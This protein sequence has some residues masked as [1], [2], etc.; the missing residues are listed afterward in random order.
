MSN[1]YYKALSLSSIDEEKF[2]ALSFL[3]GIKDFKKEEFETHGSQFE[4]PRDFISKQ[5]LIKEGDALFE[6]YM[7][8]TAFERNEIVGFIIFGDK[9]SISTGFAEVYKGNDGENEIVCNVGRESAFVSY[10]ETGIKI[11]G[12]LIYFE[13]YL[14]GVSSFGDNFIEKITDP[15]AIDKS[16]S[17]IQ[18]FH[19]KQLILEDQNTIKERHCSESE[20]EISVMRM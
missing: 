11:C 1:P 6:E 18:L 13:H 7:G 19:S 17:Y 2:K 9:D 10:D 3:M 16:D 5:N 20:D 4:F 15:D 14:Y 12:S 8:Y